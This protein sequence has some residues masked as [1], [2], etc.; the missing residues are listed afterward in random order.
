[1]YILILTIILKGTTLTIPTPPMLTF[2][3]CA[4]AAYIM[5]EPNYSAGIAPAQ[6]IDSCKQVTQ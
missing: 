3:E 2:G 5:N 6:A 4:K 1:M